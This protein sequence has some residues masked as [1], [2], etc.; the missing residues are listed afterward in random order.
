[1]SAIRLLHQ[2]GHVVR[3]IHQAL[4]TYQRPGFV[5]TQPTY[6]TLP[7]TPDG[8]PAPVSAAN[9]HAQ[10]PRSVPSTGPQQLFTTASE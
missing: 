7:M 3:D 4:E 8:R 6:P 5:C 9:A 1:M 2:V 10:L